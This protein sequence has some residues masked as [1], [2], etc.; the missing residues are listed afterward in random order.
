MTNLVKGWLAST[1]NSNAPTF[2]PGTN[3][4]KTASLN[5]FDEYIIPEHTYISNQLT[6]SSCVANAS[7][8]ALEILQG[9]RDPL[10]VKQLSRLFIYWNS[11]LAHQAT[12][13]DEGTYIHFAM[14]SLETLGVC[15][16][17]TWEY[18]TDKVFAQPNILAYKEANDNMISAFYQ[19]TS[20]DQQRLNEIE[21]AIR[22][23]HPVVFGTQVD[24]NFAAN[25]LAPVT[26]KP[27]SNIAGGHA[28][29]ITG[30]RRSPNLQFYIRNSWGPTW[31][32]NGHAW[33]SDEYIAWDETQDI[34]VGTIGVDLLK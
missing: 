29:I 11:R 17:S 19:I 10:N 16:E 4:I 14:K 21:L 20:F 2:Y 28:M 26:N 34:F 8:D 31:G 12:G 33:L 32:N 27:T 24:K 7:C 15:E 22:A 1:S 23:N 13:L 9:L 3:L 6:L 30:V 25:I 5:S 18:K